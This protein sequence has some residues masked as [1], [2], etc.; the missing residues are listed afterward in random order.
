M[1]LAFVFSVLFLPGISSPSVSVKWSFLALVVPLY[2][3][4][5]RDIRIAVSHI[6]LGCILLYAAV[7]FMWSTVGYDFLL[8]YSHLLMIVGLFII[9]SSL[10]S[11]R[12]LLIGT[13]IG[14]GINSVFVVLQFYSINLVQQA[15]SPAGLFMNK[16][17]LAEFAALVLVGLLYEKMW[18][19]TIPVLPCLVFTEARGAI[20]AIVVGIVLKLRRSAV[21]LSSMAAIGLLYGLLN[22]DASM[23]QRIEIWWDTFSNLTWFGHGWG[24]FYSTY[25]EHAANMDTLL[26]RP[27]HAH[28]DLM[29]MI[30]ELGIGSVFIVG[31]IVSLWRSRLSTELAILAAFMVEALFGFPF[32]IPTTAAVFAIV[33][34]RLCGAGPSLCD[35]FYACRMAVHGSMEKLAELLSGRQL[36]SIS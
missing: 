6:F 3:F 11:L 19:W 13:S 21:I 7:S 10:K 2:L 31:F 16:N 17:L 34:G 33:A 36:S 24:Q 25:P 27:E 22:Y 23:A 28:N 4:L 1:S 5:V 35:D 26:A 29:E 32:Y 14:L 18:W 15:T 12:P 30:Y 8:Q 20:L 9:G